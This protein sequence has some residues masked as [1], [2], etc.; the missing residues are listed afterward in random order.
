MPDT[1]PCPK[2]GSVK[3]MPVP[4]S[5]TFLCYACKHEFEPEKPFVPKRVFLSYGHDEHVSLAIHL[6]DDLRKRGHTV[7]FDVDKK[8]AETRTKR[9]ITYVHI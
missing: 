6:R 2:C 5:L 9:R 3:T 8:R 4:D 1:A 7:W